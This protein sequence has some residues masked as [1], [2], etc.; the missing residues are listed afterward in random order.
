MRQRCQEIAAPARD[1]G[2]L[3][4]PL[5]CPK[6]GG[7]VGKLLPEHF[8]ADLLPGHY[9]RRFEFASI[10]TRANVI[11]MIGD[12]LVA[13]GDK[14]ALAYIASEAVYYDLTAQRNDDFDERARCSG[15]RVLP[16]SPNRLQG[17]LAA[18]H[19][20]P[21]IGRDLLRLAAEHR[22]LGRHLDDASRV[23]NVASR[24]L[25]P[26]GERLP[27]ASSG[28]MAELPARPVV[29]PDRERED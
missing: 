3:R 12:K 7:G 28:A 20:G 16:V 6:L 25:A 22:K 15:R 29:P 24:W 4:Q 13:I 1:V 2:M 26:H 18:V 5:R 9:Q 11:V 21:Q 27:Q 17:F 19:L 14:R 10:W 23:D 8:L